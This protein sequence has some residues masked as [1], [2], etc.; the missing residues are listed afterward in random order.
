M[1]RIIRHYVVSDTA[2]YSG[3]LQGRH[4]AIENARSLARAD[5]AGG[6]VYVTRITV[7][8][9]SH[10]SEEMVRRYQRTISRTGGLLRSVVC[11]LTVVGAR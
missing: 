10:H 11:L 9:L 4:E 1:S 8:S 2:G 5:T 6:E 3:P 7:Y